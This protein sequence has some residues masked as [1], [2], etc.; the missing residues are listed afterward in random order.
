MFTF[1]LFVDVTSSSLD[2][3]LIDLFCKVVYAD[4]KLL[5]KVIKVKEAIELN[6]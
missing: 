6:R 2:C 3:D 4:G 1:V 5:V